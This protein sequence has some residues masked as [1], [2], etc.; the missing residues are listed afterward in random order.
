MRKRGDGT[1]RARSRRGGED[2]YKCEYDC[3][4]LPNAERNLSNTIDNKSVN[5]Y[6]TNV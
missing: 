1:V 4:R 3:M 5:W 6:N 2:E